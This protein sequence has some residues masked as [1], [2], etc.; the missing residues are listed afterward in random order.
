MK[1]ARIAV[2]FVSLLIFSV[3][4]S[5]ANAANC[6]NSASDL[7]GDGWGWENGRSCSVVAG[8]QAAQASASQFC[9]SRSADP[10][11]D[12]WGW[13]NG[14]S[15]K[16]SSSSVISNSN[17]IRICRNASS[18]PDGDGWGY[19]QGRSCRVGPSVTSQSSVS[20]SQSSVTSS[21]NGTTPVSVRFDKSTLRRVGGKGDNWCQTWAADGNVIT[22]MDDGEWHTSQYKY[23]SRLYRISGNAN[24]FSYR[25]IQNYPNFHTD[26]DGWFAYG[27]TSVNG[28]LYSTVSK[29]Q[30]GAWSEGP[31]RGMKLL[32]SYDNGNNWNRVDRYNNDRYLGQWDQARELINQDE[33][34]FLEESGRN[35]K[36][37]TA[38][39]FAYVSFVQNG[40]DNRA[41]RDGYVYIY[42]PEVAN[43]NQLLLARAPAN[44]LGQRSAWQ[45]FSGWNGSN[46]TWTSNI[47]NRRANMYLPERNS[48]GEYFGWYSWLPSVVW[49]AGLGKYVMVNGGT[50]AGHGM[51]NS[52][53]DYYNKWMHTKSGSLG[54]WYSD[55]PYGPWK[56]FYYT[57]HWTA[58]NSKNLTYQPKLSPKWISADGRRMTLIWSDAMRNAGGYS[59]SVNYKW[60]QMEF[61]ITTR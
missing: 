34:F 31:F 1:A 42:S 45:Y 54:L 6:S 59:H 16:V 14:R 52:T 35:G 60:N 44:Q 30:N 49:N 36:G 23:H 38:Y 4:G 46:A 41:S 61:E 24:N 39:P 18:D 51:S 20:Q 2:S 57:D 37:K 13:E 33:M 29:T 26:G 27:I 56:Q 32:R 19:E 8:S 48:R 55:T 53:N 50:Y 15:C 28:V 9:S 25:Q 11:G 5:V 47:E 21:N 3:L 58:D 10:D 40:Q 43:S 17:S 12:G 7:D 22:A